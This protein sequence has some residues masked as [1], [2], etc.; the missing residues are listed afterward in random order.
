MKDSLSET[1]DFSVSCG[2]LSQAM[3][4]CLH[5]QGVSKMYS[6]PKPFVRMAWS[7]GI[8]ILTEGMWHVA[9]ELTN[10]G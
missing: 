10:S 7:L 3:H 2:M 4:G 8:F 1:H 6:S 5:S 9:K